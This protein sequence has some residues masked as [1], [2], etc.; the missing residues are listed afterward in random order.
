MVGNSMDYA[1]RKELRNQVTAFLGADTRIYLRNNTILI[2]SP[3]VYSDKT[4]V[5][6]KITDILEGSMVFL[7]K[8]KILFLDPDH[9]VTNELKRF[10][11]L[12]E[13]II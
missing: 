5:Q 8:Y 1:M 12:A 11:I 4:T 9:T 13:E 2:D 6:T 10:R 3:R 7:R